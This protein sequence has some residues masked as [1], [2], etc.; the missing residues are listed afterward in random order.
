MSNIQGDRPNDLTEA[1]R[2]VA[3]VY[4]TPD[5]REEIKM[6]TA[7]GVKAVLAGTHHTSGMKLRNDW[8][9]WHPV[10][11]PLRAWFR[12]EYGISHP[13]DISGIVFEAA[14]ARVRGEAYDPALTVARYKA[15]WAA[16]GCDAHGEKHHED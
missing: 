6:M 5:E 16:M 13:D 1:A 15:H 14:I 3:D 4:T 8:G 7:D 9:L 12:D 10:D 11:V 2:L